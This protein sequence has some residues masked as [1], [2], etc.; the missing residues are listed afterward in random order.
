VV[1]QK[2]GVGEQIL[3]AKYFPHRSL[4]LVATL[5]CLLAG[6][7]GR[8]LPAYMQTASET[9][10]FKAGGTLAKAGCSVCHAGATNRNSLNFYGKALQGALQSSAGRT[11]TPQ[12]LHTLD[13]RDSDGDG[14][15]N[16]AEFKADT[17][18]GDPASKPSGTPPA[19]ANATGA[20][21]RATEINPFSPQALFYPSHAQHPVIVHFPIALFVF[22]LFLDLFGIRTGNR[23]LNAAAYFNLVAAAV[24][25]LVSVATGLLAWRFAFGGEPLTGDRWLLFHLV[26]GIVTTILMCLMWAIRARRPADSAKPL[27][28]AYILIGV[29]T[30]AIIALTGHFGGI[31]SGVVR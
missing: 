20:P 1:D 4:V 10:S 8:A 16:A 22:S 7:R 19:A 27:S 17:L 24:T 31:V 12:V 3:L 9:Y 14:W 21:L 23:T 5:V 2:N 15:P 29:M 30:L 26:L 25:G 28:T 11:V 6:S 18:P 13:D